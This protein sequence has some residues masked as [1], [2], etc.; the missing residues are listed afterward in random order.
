[1]KIELNIEGSQL[2]SEVKNLLDSLSAEQKN[3]MA[4]DILTKT[5]N[6][7][8]SKMKTSIAKEQALTDTNKKYNKKYRLIKNDIATESDWGYVDCDH[9]IYFNNKVKEYNDVGTYFKES[10]LKEMLEF[11][12]SKVKNLIENSPIVNEALESAKE[13]I[14]TMLPKIVH[15]AMVLY[16]TSQITQMMNGISGALMQC[17]NSNAM[18]AD[19]QNKLTQHNIY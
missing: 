14:K 13:E 19:I 4:L 8:E 9:K 17:G 6:N 18:L 3:A 1:M 7:S 2:D 11:G 10:I 15:D 16:F 5:L 12:V